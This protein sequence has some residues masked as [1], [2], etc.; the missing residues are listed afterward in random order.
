MDRKRL[1]LFIKGYSF[2]ARNMLAGIIVDKILDFLAWLDYRLLIIL[3]MWHP[4]PLTRVKLLRKRGVRIGEN[5]FVDAGVFIEITNPQTVIIEDYAAIGYGAIIYS[6]DA[7]GNT[8][9]DVP[10]RVKTTRIG[11]N[12]AIGTGSII[13][14]G[15]QIGKYAGVAPGS[16]V[17]GD[18]ADHEVVGGHPAKHLFTIEEAIPIWQDDMKANPDIYFDSPNLARPQST[19]F[20]EMLTWRQEATEVRHWTELRTGTPFDYILDYK[21]MKKS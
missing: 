3:S 7:S 18:V 8:M 6:H 13:M 21:K 5:V 10:L 14:P 20:D 2:L 11:Y 17:L 1:S 16:L 15:V 9:M 4:N 19:P 12:S